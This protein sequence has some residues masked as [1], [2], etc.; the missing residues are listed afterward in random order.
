MQNPLEA[1]RRKSRWN[2]R[3]HVE[4]LEDRTVPDTT[5]ATMLD[6][7]LQVTTV[8]PANAGLSPADRNR[9]Y[10]TNDFLVLEKAPARSSG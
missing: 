10:G 1:T 3:L 4:Q 8:V 5:P 6:P 7:N 2:C 9:L